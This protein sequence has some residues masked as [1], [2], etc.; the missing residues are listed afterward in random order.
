MK[1]RSS[2]RF[3]EFAEPAH[4]THQLSSR[5]KLGPGFND[6]TGIGKLF[7]VFRASFTHVAAGARY[8]DGIRP[9]PE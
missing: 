5:R 8:K 2:S 6:L 7:A 3:G 4:I 1:L 9:L